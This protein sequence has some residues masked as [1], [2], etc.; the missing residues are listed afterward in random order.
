MKD[1][2]DIYGI[3]YNCPA[4]ERCQDC[5]IQKVENLSFKDK[6]KWF[7]NLCDKGKYDIQKHHIKCSD[8][9]K[10]GGGKNEE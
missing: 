1:F 4:G 3:L 2:T 5:P 9:R 10:K 6:V 7:E 8:R